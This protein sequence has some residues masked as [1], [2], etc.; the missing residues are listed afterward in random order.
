MTSLD[1]HE[2]LLTTRE[3]EF[4]NNQVIFVRR[5]IQRK[6]PTS[7]SNLIDA[8]RGLMKLAQ[9]NA[10][11]KMLYGAYHYT[12]EGS[13]RYHV[14]ESLVE[15][16]K[17]NNK[18]FYIAIEPVPTDRKQIFHANSDRA[19]DSDVLE[20]LDHLREFQQQQMD[21]YQNAYTCA[22][23]RLSDLLQEITK[24]LEQFERELVV[25]EFQINLGE[26]PAFLLDLGHRATYSHH[27]RIQ[28]DLS[29][30]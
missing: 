19:V 1:K 29:L 15:H 28:F 27:V 23:V 9:T 11:T 22:Y 14:S 26:D 16:E 24:L 5:L 20:V 21:F 4:T 8:A 25:H 13:L 6:Y 3:F 30:P 10:K 2:L 18:R 12:H 7:M 17:E